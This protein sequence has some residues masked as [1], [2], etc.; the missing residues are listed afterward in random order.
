MYDAIKYFGKPGTSLEQNQSAQDEQEQEP[1]SKWVDPET[2]QIMRNLCD[3]LRSHR[4]P[5][6]EVHYQPDRSVI[7]VVEHPVSLLQ[8]TVHIR[9][10]P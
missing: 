7:C 5:L 4:S 1:Q 3:G 6:R 10:I 9:R 2:L 8:Y